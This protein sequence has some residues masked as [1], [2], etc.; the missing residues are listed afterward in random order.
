MTFLINLN[1]FADLRNYA[2]L[3]EKFNFSGY[4]KGKAFLIEAYDILTLFSHCP[5]D[6]LELILTEITQ[7]DAVTL[8][9][10][11]SDTDLLASNVTQN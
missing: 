8:Q 2:A 4:I 5:S 6:C 9:K 3:L 10:Y 11:L 7:E 1:N